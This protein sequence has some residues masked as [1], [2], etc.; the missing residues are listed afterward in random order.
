VA[1][2]STTAGRTAA[3]HAVAGT[4]LR[5]RR[6]LLVDDDASIRLLCSLNL[7]SAEFVVTGA[8]DGG[9][10]LEQATLH[11]PDPILRADSESGPRRGGR[12]RRPT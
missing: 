8:A 12:T 6:V 2:I 10:G 4:Y 7:R 3:E 5:R 1:T 11:P 9:Q